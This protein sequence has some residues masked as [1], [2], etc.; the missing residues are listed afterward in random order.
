MDATQLL[1][2]VLDVAVLAVVEDEDG[3]GY[4][5]VRR[6]RS[7]GLEEVGDASVYGT[8]RRLLGW[9]AHVVRRAVRRRAAPQVLRH[10]RPGEGDS[11]APAQGLGRVL[12]H[13]DP[14]TQQR[15]Q[16]WGGSMTTSTV[17][18]EIIVFAQGVR[19]ALADLPAEEV[20]DLTEGLEADLAE[21]LAEDLRRTLPDPAVYAAAAGWRP[22]CRGRTVPVRTGVVASLVDVLRDAQVGASAT[23]RRHPGLVAA[24][25]FLTALR[26]AWWIVRAWL[27]TWLIAAFFGMEARYWFDGAF[28]LVLIAFVVVSVQWGRGRWAFPGLRGLVVIGNVIAVVALLPVLNA[29]QSWGTETI[30]VE[31]DSGQDL[32]GVFLNGSQVTNIFGFDAAG[33]PLKDVQLVD[34]DGKPLATSVAGGNG[35]LDPDCMKNGLWAP[36]TLRNGT[37]AWNV[38]PM[39]MVEADYGD[40]TG[41]LTAVQGAEPQERPSPFKRVPAL[42]TAKKVAESD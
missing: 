42:V 35:C 31:G 4:D 1:K 20:D 24:L 10:Q 7:A 13:H 11:R 8:L 12:R 29:A 14:T 37:V 2:G 25:D 26:P 22:A 18:P 33:R 36:S 40:D 34:Q 15:I 39:R 32:T 9:R 27:A 30:H 5:V 19:E 28:W 41:N 3:Y 21:S 6:L 16:A 23:V 17:A 38:F